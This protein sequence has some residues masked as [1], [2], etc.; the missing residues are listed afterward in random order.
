MALPAH[1]KPQ[2]HKLR[3]GETLPSALKTHGFPAKAADWVFGLDA[4]RKLRTDKGYKSHT[5]LQ[6]GD[7]VYIPVMTKDQ[8]N[9]G[10]DLMMRLQFEAGVVLKVDDRQQR[11]YDTEDRIGKIESELEQI[12]SRLPPSGQALRSAA[13]ECKKTLSRS[14][15]WNDTVKCLVEIDKWGKERQKLDKETLSRVKQLESDLK[16][17]RGDLSS[18]Q[19]GLE[20][21]RQIAIAIEKYAQSVESTLRPL[22]GS[23]F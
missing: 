3:K 13:D 17:A 21:S 12:W 5:E 7:T 20:R 18:A 19:S 14:P 9:K 4:N 8:I 11:V 6:A 16:K 15:I 23:K 2:P 1:L 10:I 22:A